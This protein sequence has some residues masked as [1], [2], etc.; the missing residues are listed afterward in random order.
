M[1]K[2]GRNDR[3]PD[4]AHIIHNKPPLEI[5][6]SRLKAGA[7]ALFF[8]AF[9]AIAVGA[10]LVPTP[11]LDANGRLVI[12]VWIAVLAVGLLLPLYWV[13]TPLPL[14][15]V[16]THELTWQPNPWV[17]RTVAWADVSSITA[18]KSAFFIYAPHVTLMLV[19]RLKSDAVAAYGNKP[20]IG[21]DISALLLPMPLDDVV[22]MLRDYHEVTYYP[23]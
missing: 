6:Y 20:L 7:M 22:R 18:T 12:G 15:V 2:S 10:L 16:D 11:P 23:Y 1:D 21:L 9:V 4:V 5:Y 14:L 3:G 13:F 19:V 8:A 17:R